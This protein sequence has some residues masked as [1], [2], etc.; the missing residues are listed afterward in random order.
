MKGR[1]YSGAQ[2]AADFIAWLETTLAAWKAEHP[3]ASM[4]L[5]HHK[6]CTKSPYDCGLCRDP[7]CPKH[8][9]KR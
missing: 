6:T 5:H 7:L 2:S 8:G 4:T 3:A 1:G 9:R